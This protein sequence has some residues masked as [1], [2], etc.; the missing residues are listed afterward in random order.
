MKTRSAVRHFGGQA[1]LARALGLARQSVHA[2]G[3]V[4]PQRYQYELERLTAGKLVAT[5]PPADRPKMP[6]PTPPQEQLTSQPAS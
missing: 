5:W 4:V 6:D 2:W 1:A 3:A